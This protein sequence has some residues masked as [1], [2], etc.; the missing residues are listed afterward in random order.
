MGKKISGHIVQDWT[1]VE[2][3][4][5]RW[6]KLFQVNYPK[7]C[8]NVAHSVLNFSE[9]WCVP[10]ICRFSSLFRENIIYLNFF[11]ANLVCF[12][13]HQFC[14]CLSILSTPHLYFF[15]SDQISPYQRP[16]HNSR[17]L[18]NLCHSFLLILPYFPPQHLSSVHATHVLTSV[19]T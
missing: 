1:D 3:L 6:H 7:I 10:L 19:R 8:F 9:I 13:T 18:N 14:L 2:K 11:C 16:S 15:P 12:S 17:K 5:D 4:S